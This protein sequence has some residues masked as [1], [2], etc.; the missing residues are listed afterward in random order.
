M[1]TD[2]EKFQKVARFLAALAHGAEN[3]LGKGSNA[4][5]ALAG[6][7]FG[8][9]AV[10]QSGETLEPLQALQNL[11]QALAARGLFWEIEPFPGEDGELIRQEGKEKRLRL[12]FRTCIV[13]N[14]LFLY[15]HEQKQSLCYMAHG[16]FAGAMEKMMP[17]CS[18]KLE[19]VQACPNACLKEMI[20]E[21]K[22]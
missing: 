17:G 22:A 1:E 13:R 16:V 5:C 19:I 20:W 12:V 21:E 15:A 3:N 10:Q 2:V 4:V 11:T 7:K 9:E 6:K 14:A 18:V 8:R